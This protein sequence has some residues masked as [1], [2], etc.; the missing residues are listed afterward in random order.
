MSELL[1][2]REVKLGT[3]KM[4]AFPHL[5]LSLYCILPHVCLYRLQF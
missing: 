1:I 3:T 2:L 5:N 4:F